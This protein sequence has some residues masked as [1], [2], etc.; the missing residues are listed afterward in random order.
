MPENPQIF[1][2]HVGVIKCIAWLEDD[3]GFVSSG[4]DT[5]VYVWKLN[6]GSTD[7]KFVWEYK[8]KSVNFTCLT[9]YKPEGEK[10]PLIYATDTTRCLRELTEGENHFGKERLRFE[11]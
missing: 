7:N 6:S 8:I 3:S 5:N 4:W 1:K 11:Q 10:K 2:G 9:A